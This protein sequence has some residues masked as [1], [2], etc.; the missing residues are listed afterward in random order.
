M[1]L[2]TARRS[3]VR[4]SVTR[5]IDSFTMFGHLQKSKLDRKHHFS[6][7]V[8]SKFAKCF[9]I[10]TQIFAKVGLFRQTLSHWYLGT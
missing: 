1:T 5:W 10:N 2:R 3:I 7:K 9:L 6:D 4:Y 8:D